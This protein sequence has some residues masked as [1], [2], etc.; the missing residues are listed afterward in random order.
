MTGLRLNHP[1]ELDSL[2]EQIVSWQRE[3]FPN[4][5]VSACIKHLCKEVQELREDV[6]GEEVADCFFL[7]IAIADRMNLNLGE[8]LR[9]KLEKN[10]RRQWRKT[11]Q[12]H[13]EHIRE[14]P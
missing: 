4:Q 5:S 6:T 13:H 8:E 2:V 7:L 11:E 14:A 12:G 9:A 1:M 10:R 3:Q